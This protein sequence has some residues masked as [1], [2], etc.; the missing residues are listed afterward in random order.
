VNLDRV[1]AIARAV[2][3][4]GYILYPYRPSAIKN[5]QRWTFGGV[6]P[7]GYAESEGGDSWHMQTQ[8]LLRGN[9]AAAIEV[10][11]RFLQI[12]MRDVY[13][14]DSPCEDLP[15]MHEAAGE[16]VAALEVYDGTRFVP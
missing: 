7:R 5:R 10:R 6:F 15:Q 4:E 12:V 16:K 3:Y 2:L 9:A 8:C 14:L 13:K 1:A 11:V